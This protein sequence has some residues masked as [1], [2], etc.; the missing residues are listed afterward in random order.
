MSGQFS[1]SL[2]SKLLFFILV[3]LQLVA[4]GGGSG[5]DAAVSAAT[6]HDVV[7]AG[8]VGDGPVTGATVEVWSSRGHLISTVQSDN[9]ATF[10]SRIRV[11]RSSYPLLLKVRGGID[12]V[13][14]DVPD[15]QMVSVVLDQDSGA[16]NINPFSTLIVRIAEFLPG[17]INAANI[18]TAKAIVMDKLGFGLDPGMIAD[19][20]SSPITDENLASL[21]KASEAMGEMIRRT[22]DQFAATFSGADGDAVLNALAAD[23]QDGSLD[24]QG[25]AGTLARVTAV[26]RVVSAQVLLEALSNTLKVDGIIATTVIDQAIVT[27]RPGGD[28]VAMTGSVQITRDMLQQAQTALAA[29]GVLD[30]STEVI[31]LERIVSGIAAGEL[32]DDVANVLPADSSRSLDNAV[33]LSMTADKTQIAAVNVVTTTYPGTTDTGTTDTGTTDTGTT[34][35]VPTD[36]APTDTGTTD[37][38]PTDSGSTD[39]GNTLPV[40]TAPVISGVPVLSVTAGSAYSFQPVAS[41]AD[42]DALRFSI[43]GKPAWA[44]FSAATGRLS[45]TPGDSDT[46]TYSHI[47]ITVTDGTDSATLPDFSISVVPAPVTTGGSFDLAWTAPVN[48]AD[49][50]PLILAEIGGFRIHYGT[51]AG[52]YPNTVEV[53]D[54]SA[55]AA[56]V[57]NLAAGTTY[58]VVMTSYD[59]SGLESGPSPEIVKTAR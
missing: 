30:S 56:T 31:G 32:P 52:S 54:G 14:G 10:T 34:D 20:I 2:L 51:S 33:L 48:R 9:T 53:A 35:P 36:P 50:S 13:T 29:A 12:L 27:T 7:L 42:G 11:W 43:T 23:L 44:G 45:G 49:G 28:G 41:D 5:G 26:A 19:P 57:D 22:R 3:V 46:G 15:F 24:G 1:G 17:G 16:V 21:M 59:T 37:P 4:C 55:Q 38:A 25:A 58:H 18:G 47:A 8:S 6:A 40:N 39:A